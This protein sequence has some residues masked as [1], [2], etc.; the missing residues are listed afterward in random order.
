MSVDGKEWA[1]PKFSTGVYTS[2][3]SLADVTET[4]GYAPS[5]VIHI[6]D[7]LSANPNIQIAFG[8]S[9]T[10]LAQ[11]LEMTGSSGIITTPAVATGLDITTTGFIAKEEIQTASQENMWIAFR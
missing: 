10:L 1:K 9:S 2:A 8:N 6:E 4:L 5:L 3:S 11:S 7:Y